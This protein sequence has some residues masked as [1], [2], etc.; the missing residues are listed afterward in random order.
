[1]V[2][3]ASL[4]IVGENQELQQFTITESLERVVQSFSLKTQLLN[5]VK[6][7]SN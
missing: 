6:N 3:F 5:E 4:F 7:P 1:M 2:K